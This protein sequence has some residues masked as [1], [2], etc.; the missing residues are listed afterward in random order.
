MSTNNIPSV[1]NTSGTI[2]NRTISVNIT[3]SL[4]NFAMAGPQGAVWKPVE[5][6]QTKVFGCMNENTDAQLATN[7]LR[8]AL[9]HEVN[10]LE[11]KSTFPVALGVK[12]NCLPSHEIT[13][14]GQAYAYTILPMSQLATSHN[15]YKCDVSAE[16]SQ[17][18]R[19]EYPQWNSTNLEKEGVME[20]ANCPYVFVKQD[21]PIIALLR[22]NSSLIGCDI[23][24]QPKIDNE[25]FK[26]TRQVLAACCQ[27]LR[28]KV[29]NKIASNDLNTF[30]I[31]LE[32]LGA[33]GWDDI[34]DVHVPLHDFLA[35]P[36]RTPDENEK[37]KRTHVERFLSTPFSYMARIQVKYEV[38][39]PT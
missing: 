34:N 36:L 3:G 6:K 11:H 9:I 13:D 30:Q 4:A 21:H 16:N 7:Q 33:E 2:L 10:V 27:T 37:V 8:T 1:E 26:V 12:I 24:Q 22:S 35:D 14:L 20:L 38:Q 39:S 29:L 32:R 15:I 31:Q 28:T 25:W 17:N 19:N 23:D 18:W 5:G